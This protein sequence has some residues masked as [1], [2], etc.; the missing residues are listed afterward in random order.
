MGVEGG[1]VG[2]GGKGR[3]EWKKA[4]GVTGLEWTR[5]SDIKRKEERE[6][7]GHG[8]NIEELFVDE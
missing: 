4:K 6:K 5:A 3:R 8:E 1:R 7:G 2:G